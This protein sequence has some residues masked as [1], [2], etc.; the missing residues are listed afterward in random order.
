MP[1]WDCI[2]DTDWEKCIP[3]IVI[4]LKN[5]SSDFI[6]LIFLITLIFPY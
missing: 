4:L 2:I 6:A 1:T 5:D 3:E